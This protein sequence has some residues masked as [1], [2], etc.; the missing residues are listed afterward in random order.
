MPK[1]PE[2]Y[3]KTVELL[4]RA[5]MARRVP[6]PGCGGGHSVLDVH[7]IDLTELYNAGASI[8]DLRMWLAAE[9]EISVERSTIWR[10]LKRWKE[11]KLR[12]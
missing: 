8:A 5:A 6:R 2:G 9:K 3:E 7:R 4:K 10:R 12:G 1:S 11:V